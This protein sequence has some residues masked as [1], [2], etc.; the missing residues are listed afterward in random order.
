LVRDLSD[1]ITQERLSIE[2]MTTTTDRD[3]GTAHVTLQLSVQE[4]EQLARLIK[5]LSGVPN[6]L[7]VRRQR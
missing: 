6:V 2:A 1:I 4:L 5:R 7:S 3:A